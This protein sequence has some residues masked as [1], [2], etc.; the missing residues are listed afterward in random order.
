MSPIPFSL[1][2]ARHA[3]IATRALK[4]LVAAT[5][6]VAAGCGGG[7]SQFEPFVPE[8]MFAFG[9][10]A[11]ALTSTAPAGRNY[12]I[13]GI[14]GNGTTDNTADDFFDCTLQP[15]WV[16]SLA[17]LYGFV[18]AECNPNNALA[19]AH[20]RSAPGARVAEVEAQVEAQSQRDPQAADGGFRDKDIV[21]LMVGVN[22][23]LELYGQYDGSNE[24]ALVAEAS[25]RGNRAARVVNRLV[26][27]RAKVVVSNIP[28]L[29]LTPFALK[30]NTANPGSDRSGLLSRLSSAFNERLGVSLLIDGRFVAFVQTDQR[31]LVMNRSPASFGL[32]NTTD[33][34]CATPPPDCTNNTLVP[35]AIGNAYLW[36]GDYLL[37]YLGQT[38]VADLAIARALR[39]PF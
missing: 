31:V 32:V 39:N 14:N 36:A 37:S 30:Q 25:A 10:E 4:L 3:H 2:P 33:A 13:N 23:I 6:A 16:Q 20:N 22:D 17:S 5:F 35:D 8:R 21:S 29:G 18:F 24:A 28:D 19:K 1:L 15:N 9:D 26:D 11:S 27:L 12:G 34:V 7:T 38:Q